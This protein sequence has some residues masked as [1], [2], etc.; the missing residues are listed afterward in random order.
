MTEQSCVVILLCK[1]DG[2]RAHEWWWMRVSVGPDTVQDVVVV[3]FYD[4]VR[5]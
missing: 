2:R 4:R 1:V 3:G 5:E